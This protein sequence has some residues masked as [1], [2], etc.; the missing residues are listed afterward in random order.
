MDQLY[1]K[2]QQIELQFANKVYLNV[3]FMTDSI[4]NRTFSIFR[5]EYL[6]YKSE[7]DSLG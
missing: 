5:T 6:K 3:N 4:E 7:N 2:N 1:F